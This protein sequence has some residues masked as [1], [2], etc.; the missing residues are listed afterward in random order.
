MHRFRH[1]AYLKIMKQFF[2]VA[3][4]ILQSALVMAQDW[5]P[6]QMYGG[7]KTPSINYPTYSV[8]L[9]EELYHPKLKKPSTTEVQI[10]RGGEFWSLDY[11]ESQ[12]IISDGENIFILY[13]NEKRLEMTF[14]F[15]FKDRIQNPFFYPYDSFEVIESTEEMTT[16]K[17]YLETEEEL[18][19]IVSYRQSDCTPHKIEVF[20]KDERRRV[21]SYLDWELYIDI[22][23][24]DFT[25]DLQE[26]RNQGWTVEDRR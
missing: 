20:Y 10:V 23:P 9:K 6:E 13:P 11:G 4:L 14:G 5:T 16:V 3:L 7:C 19:R 1:L 18:Y 22:F 15:K 26:L 2:F 12:E 17:L 8:T 25:V 24:S 21:Y